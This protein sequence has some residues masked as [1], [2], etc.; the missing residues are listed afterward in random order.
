MITKS[1]QYVISLSTPDQFF[2]QSISQTVFWNVFVPSNYQITPKAFPPRAAPTF[3][4]PLPNMRFQFVCASSA[5]FQPVDILLLARLFGAGGKG[6][7]PRGCLCLPPGQ[8]LV[9]LYNSKILMTRQIGGCAQGPA[10]SWA[11]YR[12][13]TR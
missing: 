7:S 12:K 1:S 9:V 5:N 13:E 6:E 8:K 2:Q 10:L 3:P 11:N 4:S